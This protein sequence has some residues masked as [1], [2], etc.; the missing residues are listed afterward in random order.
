MCGTQ[1]DDLLVDAL[2]DEDAGVR[3]LLLTLL[4]PSSAPLGGLELLLVFIETNIFISIEFY[5]IIQ[6]EL[7]RNNQF[8]DLSTIWFNI[9]A[10]KSNQLAY[11]TLIGFNRNNDAVY[12]YFSFT[13]FYL[14]LPLPRLNFSLAHVLLRKFAYVLLRQLTPHIF[15]YFQHLVP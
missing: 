9:D 2:F 11:S 15:L 13:S 4:D 3:L 12:H 7:S 1:T 5:N 6:T 10:D 8:K 14:L